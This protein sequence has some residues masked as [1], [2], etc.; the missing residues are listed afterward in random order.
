MRL[1]RMGRE[2]FLLKEVSLALRAM[3]ND[4]FAWPKKSYQKKGQ[5]PPIRSPLSS[6]LTSATAPT[7]RADGTR[8]RAL[9]GPPPLARHPCLATWCCGLVSA[10][11]RGIQ[12][13]AR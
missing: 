6:P 9:H 10:N 3:A 12:Y 11:Q 1:C 13:R 7:E 2:E 5:A 4:F 8:R